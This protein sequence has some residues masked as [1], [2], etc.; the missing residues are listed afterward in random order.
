MTPTTQTLIN[1]SKSKRGWSYYSNYF[2]CQR[3][4]AF[5]HE[6]QLEFPSNPAQVL[7]SMVH[8]GL[9]HFF[10]RTGTRQPNGLVWNGGRVK[11]PDFFFAPIDAICEYARLFDADEWL[12]CAI[13]TYTE[14]LTCGLGDPVKGYNFNPS[15]SLLHDGVATARQGGYDVIEAVEQEYTAYLGEIEFERGRPVFGLWIGQEVDDKLVHTTVEG[16]QYVITPTLLDCPGHEDH[17][18][19]IYI[20]R[21]FDLIARSRKTLKVY[22]DD[23]K[24][25]GHD[26][27]SSRVLEYRNDG[28]FSLCRIF[29]RQLYGPEFG[30]ARLHL[31]AKS[32]GSDPPAKLTQLHDMPDMHLDYSFAND[33]YLAAHGIA[34]GQMN[35]VDRHGR[36]DPFQWPAARNMEVCKGI[37]ICD[38][39]ELCRCG[40]SAIM[41]DGRPMMLSKPRMKR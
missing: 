22:V 2:R 38:A 15:H 8:V 31:V 5:K 25:T 14:W 17:G 29:G 1:A 20:S 9:A 16:V 26:T 30:G 6:A 7:G 39:M 41:G 11:D 19:P 4:H 18:T 12:Q 32:T 40:P 28:Q 34:Q 24:V 10:A 27:S 37:F 3:L 36:P 23:H 35:N 21:R 33:L 13:D